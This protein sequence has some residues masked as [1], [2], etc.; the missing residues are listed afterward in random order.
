MDEQL[1][2]REYWLQGHD[3]FRMGRRKRHDVDELLEIVAPVGSQVPADWSILEG[4]LGFKL[5]SDYKKV[6]D[7]F[8]AGSFMNLEVCAPGVL[9][10]R[11]S[12]V[13]LVDRLRLVV[14]DFR[15]QFRSPAI[16]P[17][18]PE[19]GG[20]IPWGEVDG[21]WF[22][23]WVPF[24]DDPDEWPVVFTEPNLSA[25]WKTYSTFS[26]YVIEYLT[27]PRGRFGSMSPQEFPLQGDPVFTP[28]S[29]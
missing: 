12:M 7:A 11:F 28:A 20:L 15:S 3:P 5:P 17:Y 25:L 6:I 22:H 10:G 4:D 1:P 18:F 21:G 29:Y 27:P 2:Y 24:G 8:G 14:S 19:E 13:N 26:E 9:D 23:F 16:A